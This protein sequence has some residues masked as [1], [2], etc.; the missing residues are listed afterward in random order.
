MVKEL[1][2]LTL[3]GRKETRGKTYPLFLERF[4]LFISI[5]FSIYLVYLIMNNFDL[6]IWIKIILNFC[7]APIFALS[8]AEIIGRLIQKMST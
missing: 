4:G 2:K 8:I 1:N 3:I 6:S 7:I 5:I